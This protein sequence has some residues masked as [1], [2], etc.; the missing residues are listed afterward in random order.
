M[1]I[2][3]KILLS[4]IIFIFCLNEVQSNPG[5]TLKPTP[6]NIKPH[7][8][9]KAAIMSAI[10]PGLGQAYNHKYWKIPIIYAGMAGLGYV[11]KF[12]NDYYQRFRKAYVYRVDG[13]PLTVDAYEGEYTESNLNTLQEFYHR[14]RDLSII[15]CAAFYVLNI[16]DAT[17][18]AHLYYFDVSDD[19]S[20]KI[21]PSAFI[22]G[23]Q[24]A[25]G[26]RLSLTL[27]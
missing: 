18:D 14:N 10:L 16:I 15:G 13:D 22:A 9:K 8:P 6:E 26:I 1:I 21:N 23:N 2:S 24:Q 12:N 19:L 27:K 3:L 17:V 20:L 5:D 11:V 4:S 7:S 25:M